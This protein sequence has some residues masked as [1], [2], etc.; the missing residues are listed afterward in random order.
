MSSSRKADRITLDRLERWEILRRLPEYRQVWDEALQWRTENPAASEDDFSRLLQA[1]GEPFGLVS[2]VDYRRELSPES[3]HYAF[4]LPRAPVRLTNWS[5]SFECLQPQVLEVAIDLRASR[6]SIE[7]A[8]AALL[9]RYGR[10]PKKGRRRPRADEEKIKK[11]Y[12]AWD[13]WKERKTFPQIGRLLYPGKDFEQAADLARKDFLTAHLKIMRRP[14]LAGESARAL[15]RAHLQKPCPT[16][17]DRTCLATG[18][19][20]D[21]ASAYVNQD[22]VGRKE[23]LP[24]YD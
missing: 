5:F 8:L 7:A 11:R 13:H 17:K 1:R 14:Y 3:A 19:P 20:C 18:K 4:G 22:E 2:L 6:K 16:C 24:K 23:A 10:W 12:Q 9:D 21:E 15:Q